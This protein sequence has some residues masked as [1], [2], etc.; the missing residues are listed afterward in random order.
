[1]ATQYQPTRRTRP[2]TA[3][4]LWRLADQGRANGVTILSECISG[5]RFASSATRPGTV[6]R[7]TA[8]SCTCPG[9]CQHQRC[10]H[11]S[12]LLA[13]LGWLPDVATD[14]PEPDPPAAPAVCSECHGR[15]F[16]PVCTGHPTAAGVVTCE[17]PRCGGSGRRPAPRPIIAVDFAAAP[18]AA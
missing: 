5:E 9:F 12:L 16:D 8:Y 1:M 17:C 10:Q 7:L 11:H 14:D 2:A 4:D 3:A 18:L 13:E 15:G 6:Y